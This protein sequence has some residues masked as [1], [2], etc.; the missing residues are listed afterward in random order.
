M[1]LNEITNICTFRCK[2]KPSPIGGLNYPFLVFKEKKICFYM[3]IHN[4]NISLVYVLMPIQCIPMLSS[5]MIFLLLMFAVIA[6]TVQTCPTLVNITNSQISTTLTEYDT[7]V[8]VT[9]HHGYQ[10]EGMNV[11]SLWLRCTDGATWNDTSAVDCIGKHMPY[12]PHKSYSMLKN[13]DPY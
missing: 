4:I 11:T 3:Y 5:I 8:N 1:C 10:F 9:C 13:A 6:Y 2:L 12:R 7:I